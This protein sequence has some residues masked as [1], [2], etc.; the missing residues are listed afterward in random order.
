[1]IERLEVTGGL[2]NNGG[3]SES[4]LRN[5]EVGVQPVWNYVIQTM[6]DDG[7]PVER[8]YPTEGT[9]AWFIQ[10]TIHAEAENPELAHTLFRNGI[11]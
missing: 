8:V 7:L 3:E 4:L 1:L 9:K 2:W 5:E 11:P 6:Q 10:H